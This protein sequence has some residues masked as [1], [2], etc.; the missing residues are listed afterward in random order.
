VLGFLAFE[1]WVIKLQSNLSLPFI[2]IVQLQSSVLHV[3]LQ[4]QGS[5]LS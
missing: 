4:K 3:L 1:N 2:V 5:K